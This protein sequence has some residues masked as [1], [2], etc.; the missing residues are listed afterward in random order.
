MDERLISILIFID[1]QQRQY[2]SPPSIREIC[3]H[4]YYASTS[5]G[6]HW[7]DQVE[8]SGLIERIHGRARGIRITDFGRKEID[9][10]VATN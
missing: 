1:Q 7:L 3:E 10:A 8:K 9:H 2:G 6:N 4:F 5:V